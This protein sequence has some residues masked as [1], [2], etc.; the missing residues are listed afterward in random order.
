MNIQLQ[1]REAEYLMKLF[2]KIKKW[3]DDKTWS[4]IPI[5]DCIEIRRK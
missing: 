2:F 3:L 1:A 4:V 5:H